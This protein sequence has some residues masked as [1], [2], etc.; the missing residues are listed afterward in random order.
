MVWRSYAQRCK[1]PGTSDCQEQLHGQSIL[2]YRPQTNRLLQ[3]PAAGGAGTPDA[4]GRLP[5]AAAA[6]RRGALGQRGGPPTAERQPEGAPA[7]VTKTH[8]HACTHQM[9]CANC[10][11]RWS[12]ELVLLPLSWYLLPLLQKHL[13]V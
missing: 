6:H 11:W 3:G 7:H 8:A 12:A 13:I 10:S 2:P 9:Q 5:S 4:L 1:A